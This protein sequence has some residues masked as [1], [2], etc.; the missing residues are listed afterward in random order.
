[1]K[2]GEKVRVRIPK[3][4]RKESGI[5]DNL[6]KYDGQVYRISKT[7][8]VHGNA[9]TYRYYELEGVNTEWGMPYAF[10]EEWLELTE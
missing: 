10:M 1:M 8:V 4:D 5:F 3:F 6:R 9:G 7:G 2:K